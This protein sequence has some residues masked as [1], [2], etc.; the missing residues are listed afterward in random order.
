MKQILQ[1]YRT[2]EIWLAEVPAPAVGPGLVV[3]RTAC[4]VLSAGTERTMLAL[5][6]SSLLDKA[7]RRPDLVRQ[8][9]RTLRREGFRSTVD[10][11]RSRLDAP[12]S[13]GYSAAGRV[14]EAGRRVSGFRPG[15]RVALAGV[16]YAT[17]AEFNAAPARLCVPVPAEVSDAD[18]AFA[19]LGAIALQGV[20]QA[21]PL[22]GERVAVVGLGL[23]GLL[24][25]QILKANG[26]GVLGVDPD[27]ERAARA[28]ALGADAAV[29]ADAGAACD[30]FTGGRGADAVLITAAASSDGPLAL[31]AEMSR[32]KGRVVAVGLVGL[33]VPR[34][35]FYRKELDLRLSMSYGPGRYDP[36]YEEG[37]R[38]YPFAYVRFT[39][40][41][42]ME[43]FLYLVA[44]GRVTPSALVTHHIPFDDA[45]EA[46][47]LLDL[48]R[49]RRGSDTGRPLGILL[50]YRPDVPP[51]RTVECSAVRPPAAS[52]ETLGVGLVGAG[53]FAVGV[54]VP[55]LAA[56]GVRF[57]GVCTRTGATAQRVAERF[58]ARFATTEPARLFD[59]EG[60]DA[61]IIAARPAA[62]AALAAVALRAGKHVFVEK[63]L[64]LA[65]TDLQAVE[66][67]LRD[68]G[69]AGR[70]PCL[71]VGF[72][73]RFSPHA[74]AVRAVFRER[75]APMAIVYRV[76]A[77]PAPT[78]GWRRD[79]DEGGGRLIG[80][81]CHFVDFCGAV[82]D[83]RPIMVSAFTL[84]GDGGAGPAADSVMLN[85][86]YADGSLAAVH[87]LGGG[88]AGLPKERCELFADGRSAVIDDFRT[89]TFHGG[90]RRV[91]GAQAKGFAEE[92]R[93]FLDVCRHG[94]PWPIPWASLVSAHRVCF[95]ALRSLE[96][97]ATV[98]VDPAEGRARDLVVALGVPSPHPRRRER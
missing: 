89:T 29:S 23:I 54:L 25:V 75:R 24:T 93:A 71:M 42:N 61:V 16:G 46:Y 72:N 47:A 88:H 2:G 70:V 78:D 32:R 81:G 30:A 7:R 48:G 98:A 64:A 67:A 17:H 83:N 59:D 20:R 19:T 63:P 51:H 57:T 60:T 1:S 14:L 31:A 69:E 49:P 26:C 56:A 10:K 9:L 94:G 22:I 8:V 65:E 73:R 34:D 40:Q 97:G 12:V 77:G 68:A 82:I 90:G 36:D 5:A 4:S 27:E 13:L 43:S 39:E 55:R 52:G 84:D 95:A 80:E 58:D 53:R 79:P 76:N 91:R 85:I 87:Y 21:Q 45:L 15:D 28:R 11:V 44:Q 38:D 92:L 37:G 96:T 41:R 35:P 50:E 66:R 62:H 86:R 3:A 33:R 74:R 6:R 18:A